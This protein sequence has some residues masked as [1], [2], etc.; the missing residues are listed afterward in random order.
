M[1]LEKVDAAAAFVM[2]NWDELGVVEHDGILH[3][4]AAIKRRN[5]KGGVD[6]VPVALRNISNAQRFNARVMARDYTLRLKFDL[7]RDKALFDELENYA[8]LAYAIR[9]PAPPFD[10]HVAS[11][12]DLLKLYDQQSLVEL[13]GR[14]NV[15]IEMLD[16][17]FGQLDADQL[18]Q[19]IA[20]IAR[21]KNP[22]PLAGMPGHAQFT[23]IVLMALEALHSPNRPSWLQPREISRAAS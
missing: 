2:D 6:E 12:D 18:W 15:W 11:I 20:R 14:Y 13:W 17:R 4:P 23:C 9:E 22:S 1:G 5:R 8:I 16:P 10:Q 21:E 3:V 7:D 19:L